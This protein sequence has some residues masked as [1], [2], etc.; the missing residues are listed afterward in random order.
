MNAVSRLI[1]S[2]DLNALRQY[3]SHKR[4]KVFERA[5]AESIAE[6]NGSVG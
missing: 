6:H 4:L 2:L 5:A 1:D 3:D